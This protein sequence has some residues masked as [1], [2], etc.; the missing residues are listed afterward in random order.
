MPPDQIDQQIDLAR[1]ARNYSEEF[2]LFPRFWRDYAYPRALT[3]VTA[4]FDPAGRAVIPDAS[5]VYA[6]LVQP[7]V[8]PVLNGSYIMY[9]GQ[10]KSLYERYGDYLAEA[11]GTGKRIHT[12]EMFRNYAGYLHFTYALVPEAEITE[13]EDALIEALWPPMNYQVP[14]TIR[15]AVR[16][17]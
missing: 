13:A 17:V 1:E 7:G 9:V 11:R 12:R 8:A 5:G 14:A 6:F 2:M 4:P 3:W 10:A 16:I 15:G